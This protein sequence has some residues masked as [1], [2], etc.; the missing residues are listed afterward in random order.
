MMLREKIEKALDRVRP[1]VKDQGGEIHLIDVEKN[2]EVKVQVAGS[3]A[4]CCV[5]CGMDF[6][7][8]IER[9]LKADVPEVKKIVVE[10]GS[11]ARAATSF[12]GNYGVGD[13][14]P[15]GHP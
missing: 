6:N 12:Q 10:R 1:L 4:A 11:T 5:G 9:V 7:S 14:T 2:G 13:P 8:E 3:C 15:P